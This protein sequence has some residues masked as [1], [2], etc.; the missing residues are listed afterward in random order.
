MVVT[1]N[2]E[3]ELLRENAIIVS[4]TL[5]E[6]AKH[7]APGVKTI[8]LDNI[9][10]EFIRSEGAVPGFKGYRGFPGTLCISVNE[11]VVH[12][13][14]G[15]RVLKNGDVVSIDCGCIKHGYY[16]D[17]A[18]TF[19]VGEVK[20]EV[21]DLLRRTKESLFRGLN[22]A[23]TGKRVGDISSAVQD[24][25]ESFGY[26]VVRELVGHGLGKQLHEKP[27]IPNYGRQGA[28]PKLQEGLVICI[29]PMIN[30]GVKNVVQASDGWTIRTSDRQPS[31]HY[32]LTVVVRKEKPD[33]LSTFSY[34]EEVLGPERII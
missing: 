14:P 1:T 2:E 30:L 20:P 9:A 25:V 26:S 3:V 31:A 34:I 11:E 16:G 15:E 4:K 5:A 19:P 17:S 33:V 21:M 23:L 10:E 12:G 13:I 22:M 7:I 24:F 6:V 32:E 28:G 8:T 18:Y 27:D 29:E